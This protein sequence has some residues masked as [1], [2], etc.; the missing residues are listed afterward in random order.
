MKSAPRHKSNQL[1]TPWATVRVRKVA[2]GWQAQ[3]K[4]PYQHTFR[5]WGP[6]AETMD[7]A[8]YWAFDFLVFSK[9]RMNT[10]KK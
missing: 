10:V 6:F 1:E 9:P 7:H 8:Y 4:Y 3:A 2:N 5:N